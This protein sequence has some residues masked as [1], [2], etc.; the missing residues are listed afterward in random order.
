MFYEN[1][2]STAELAG[3]ELDAIRHLL[4]PEYQNFSTAELQ[5]LMQEATEELSSEERQEFLGLVTG[6]ASAFVPK[7]VK[8]GAKLIGRG[9]RGIIRKT[10][11]KRFRGSSNVAL[12]KLMGMLRDPRVLSVL[13]GRFLNGFTN[14]RFGKTK[15]RVVVRKKGGRRE[16]NDISSEALLSTIKYL[17]ESALESAESLSGPQINNYLTD[18]N[19]R[20]VCNPL[21]EKERAEVLLDKLFSPQFN[22]EETYADDNID[23]ELLEDQQSSAYHNY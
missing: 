16:I 8:A 9:V 20:F 1:Y 17:A 13:G 2:E 23:E 22:A 11:S 21:N 15:I 6:I 3:K 18:E 5:D 7:L 14:K 19:G 12:A 10:K 4:S